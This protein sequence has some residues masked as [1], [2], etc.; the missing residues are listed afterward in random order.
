MGNR[1]RP[2][3]WEVAGR[4][5]AGRLASLIGEAGLFS[6]VC[7]GELIK[8]LS[9]PPQKPVTRSQLRLACSTEGQ[10]QVGIKVEKCFRN[11]TVW[12]LTKYPLKLGLDF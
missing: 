11:S 6:P 8:V 3:G 2:G 9:P 4:W 1:E 7:D 12:T 5:K 10:G